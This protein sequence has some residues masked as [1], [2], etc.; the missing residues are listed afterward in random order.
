MKSLA[1]RRK[2]VGLMTGNSQPDLYHNLFFQKAQQYAKEGFIYSD[3]TSLTYE[4]TSKAVKKFAFSL[5]KLG[6]NEKQQNVSLIFPNYAELVISKLSTSV[7]GQ[8]AV[9]LNYRLNKNEM[10]YLIN[11]SDSDYIITIDKWRSSDYINMLRDICPEVFEGKVSQQFPHLKKI[12]VYSPERHKYEG[13][14]DFY[15]LI[16]A[17]DEHEAE[18]FV[19]ETLNAQN[20]HIEDLSDIMYTSGTTSHP[21]GVL[22][23]HDMVW[24]V[25]LGTC[26]NRGY[27]EGRR[28]YVPIPLYH[29]FGYIIGLIG[30]T[31]VGGAVILQDDFDEVE[32]L[33]LIR[34]FSVDDM[35]CVPTIAIRLLKAFKSQDE[36]LQLDAMYCAGAEV[37]ITLWEE[38]KYVAKIKELITGYGMTELASGVLQSDPEDDISY[39]VNFVGKTIP[40]GHVGLEELNGNNIEFKIR[41]NDTREFLSFGKE[42][43]LVCRGPITTKGYY[44]KSYE[45]KATVQDGW[46]NTGDLAI[47]HDNGYFTLTGRLKEIYRIGAENVA[48]KEIEEVFTSHKEVNQAYVIGVPDPLLGE[49]GL[50][51]IVLEDHS[52]LTENDLLN[53]VSER[54]ARFK[55]PKFI[56]IIKDQ[57]LPKTAT[58]KIQK[59]KLKDLFTE[60]INTIKNG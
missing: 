32:A 39:L 5:Y 36:P 31:M 52:T 23:T 2:A 15:E 21:K 8:V 13:T 51:W 48:P 22:V 35:L 6:F 44:N 56:K 57:E 25:A 34:K 1:E 41:D 38:L 9:P 11:Q 50:A 49:V 27:Q 42:G 26:I 59:F 17:A 24:R 20:V 33:K 18:Q 28:I 58:G 3:S 53:Y 14:Y 29:C 16:N 43:E 4:E 45:T 7:L 47:M 54:L 46:L 10:S 19:A 30:A 55:I 37:P 12:I 40:G 60:D